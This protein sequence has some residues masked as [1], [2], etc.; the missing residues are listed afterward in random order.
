MKTQLIILEQG[1]IIVSD[2]EIKEGDWYF[3]NTTGMKIASPTGV[4]Q[5]S[6][7]EVVCK[8]NNLS[9][10]VYKIIAGH[11]DLPT[12]SYSA[13]SDE[14]C[15]KI[16][17]INVENYSKLEFPPD[18]NVQGDEL[19]YYERMAFIKGFKKAQSLND[20]KFSLEDMNKIL[21]YLTSPNLADENRVVVARNYIQS[22]QQPKVFDIEVEMEQVKCLTNKY[23]NQP[24]N[25]IGFAVDYKY[26]SQPKITNNSIKITKVLTQ[27]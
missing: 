9:S 4:Y 22:L 18:F 1:N 27:I 15:E 10:N 8:L 23:K 5:Q 13:L 16:G 6:K 17:Y 21:S 25:I 20:K 12:I 19:D 2:E 3:L 7:K 14:D 11:Q 24:K 26:K